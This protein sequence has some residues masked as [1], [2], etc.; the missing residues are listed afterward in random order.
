MQNTELKNKNIKFIAKI[1]G[2]HKKLRVVKALPNPLLCS[3]KLAMTIHVT[4]V[5][6]FL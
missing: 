4:S 6:L 3:R 1:K 5:R 2:L